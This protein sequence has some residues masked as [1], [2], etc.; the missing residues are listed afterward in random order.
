M[1]G[2]VVARRGRLASSSHR[3][4]ASLGSSEIE[5]SVVQRRELVQSIWFDKGR[6]LGACRRDELRTGICERIDGLDQP[7]IADGH[8]HEATFRVEEGCIR[9]A[10]KG[11]LPPHV[12]GVGVNFDK[13]TTVTRYVE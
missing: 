10:R 8:M 12:S 4:G 5:N 9:H 11:P 6:R 3:I 2:A 13:Q 7:G 1:L